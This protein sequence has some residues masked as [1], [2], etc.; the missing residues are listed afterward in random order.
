MLGRKSVSL[1]GSH[2]KEKFSEDSNPYLEKLSF[3]ERISPYLISH[4]GEQNL[5]FFSI[6]SFG[7]GTALFFIGTELQSRIIL[8]LG[9]PFLL[10][11]YVFY[12][13]R[14]YYLS[15]TCKKCGREFAYIETKKPIV[16]DDWSQIIKITRYYRCKHCGHENMETKN[17]VS[18]YV[19]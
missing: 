13:A 5:L 8:F 15:R 14:S 10:L 4:Y 1:K 11:V 3:V 16:M 17:T 2:A 12:E 7:V 6:V 19:P 9:I 18:T